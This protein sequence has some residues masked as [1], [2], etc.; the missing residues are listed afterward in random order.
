MDAALAWALRKL[1]LPAVSS[2]AGRTNPA[3]MSAVA[4]H[5]I[6]HQQISL[7]LCP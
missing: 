7:N 6:E 3:S 2:V 1:L 4:T 5:S